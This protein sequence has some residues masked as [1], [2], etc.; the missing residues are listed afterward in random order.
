MYSADEE[1]RLKS[2]KN[3][4]QKMKRIQE[5]K[6]QLAAIE[7]RKANALKNY[8]A[9]IAKIDQDATDL[10]A[11]LESVKAAEKIARA[12]P[13]TIGM[14]TQTN[15]KIT[16]TFGGWDGKSYDG[17]GATLR[18]WTSK[19][20]PDKKFVKTSHYGGVFHEVL[21]EKH[22]KSGLNRVTYFAD[23]K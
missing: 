2:K 12:T 4:V 5:I 8:E 14:F 13:K 18:V 10:Q 3:E 21:N 15:E 20:Y 9:A 11:E 17:E 7:T 19:H 6:N 1:T 23:C 16:V 22:E